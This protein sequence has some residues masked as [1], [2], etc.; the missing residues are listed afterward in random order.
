MKNGVLE[1]WSIGPKLED[2]GEKIPDG[3]LTVR[4]FVFSITPLLH[5]ARE[6]MKY[7]E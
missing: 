1:D 7:K 5:D 2:Q 4:L 6:F 3:A